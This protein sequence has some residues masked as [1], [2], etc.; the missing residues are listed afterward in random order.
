MSIL[1]AVGAVKVLIKCVLHYYMP[2]MPD[3]AVVRRASW[4][5]PLKTRWRVTKRNFRQVCHRGQGCRFDLNFTVSVIDHFHRSSPRVLLQTWWQVPHR[6][7]V[8]HH[9]PL[10]INVWSSRTG[11]LFQYVLLWLHQCFRSE[12]VIIFRYYRYFFI[13][14]SFPDRATGLLCGRGYGKKRFIQYLMW[15]LSRTTFR[16]NLD[17]SFA[18]TRYE[19]RFEI[20]ILYIVKYWAAL[21]FDGCQHSLRYKKVGSWKLEF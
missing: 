18:Q 7:G 3:V 21:K 10:S 12:G 13:R 1:E 17:R 15:S 5:K 14:W 9:S 8:C 20:G 16:H 11:R 19:Q 2:C 6:C 4:I